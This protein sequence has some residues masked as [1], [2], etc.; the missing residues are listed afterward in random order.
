MGSSPS[1]AVLAVS[2]DVYHVYL[3]TGFD[4]PDKGT[5][6]K[7]DQGNIQII[8]N[9]G[10]NDDP[11]ATVKESEVLVFRDRKFD[12]DNEG[13]V[14]LEFF[15][16]KEKGV[17]EPK[18]V[19]I[20]IEGKGC[21]S[22]C[23]V[24]PLYIRE[25]TIV[26]NQVTHRFPIHNYL[27]PYTPCSACC[28]SSEKDEPQHGCAP[29]LY[30]Q[31]G[32]GSVH[33]DELEGFIKTARDKELN[34][35]KSM[36]PW[37]REDKVGPICGYVGYKKYNDLPRFLQFRQAWIDSFATSIVEGQR[38][39]IPAV[40]L[41][42][43]CGCC[44]EAPER[45]FKSF[46]HY[47]DCFVHMGEK[48]GWSKSEI[49][50]GLKVGQIFQQDPEF[51]RQIIQGPNSTKL[52]KVEE[53]SETWKA[54]ID[55]IPT[56]VID[57]EDIN[58][59][60]SD[61]RLYEIKN[62][63]TLEGIKHGGKLSK[64][65][66]GH[67]QTWYVTHADVLLFHSK[68]R[69]EE[70]AFVPILIR[71]E[72]KNDGEP[73]TFWYP[74]ENDVQKEDP[75]YLAWLFAK[76]HFRCADWGVYS[77]GTHYARAHAQNEVFAVSMYR[78]LSSSHPLFRLLKPHFQGIVGVNC[79]ARESLI[80]SD[81]NAFAKFMSSGDD[82]PQLLVNCCKELH[83]D[84][85]VVP[86][87]FET[88]GLKDVPN[89]FFR[90]DCEALWEI[91]LNYVQEMVDLS[92]HDDK[93]VTED[94]E[95]QHFV[96]EILEPGFKGFGGAG[97]PDSLTSKEKLVEYLTV[98]IFNVSCY[99]TGVNFQINKYLG[100]V[101]N[102]PPSLRTPPPKQDDVITMDH[103]MK[104]LPQ[105]ECAL[106]IMVITEVLGNFSPIERFY[107]ETKAEHKLGYLGENMAVSE[108]QEGCIKR[109]V[110]QMEGL[111]DTITKRNEGKYLAY[112]V[113]S[114]QNIPITT[115]T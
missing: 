19:K 39:I 27:S 55:K 99:H 43:L 57:G 9:P 56:H 34:I 44:G 86:K 25:V 28:G 70:E 11:K 10:A 79:Q 109:M 82:L 6:K 22:C 114:P 62:S 18:L 76:M 110:V 98:L 89:Y 51:G 38:K 16:D 49:K 106:A 24:D 33:H 68:A 94:H 60:I 23:C 96:K 91:L 37:E 104:S 107:V 72:N 93:T 1:R 48:V 66:T 103:I 20:E 15:V 75:T 83:Y 65:I 112:N 26:W 80:A 61:G 30:A 105:Y 59:V 32:G 41:N 14:D 21:S 115:Q 64:K 85:M 17:G 90:D 40:L 3:H 100:Y 101:P 45:D 50:D 7:W 63:G 58:T 69:P 84:N 53:L 29:Y 2:S 73:E 87:D 92:Y 54:G 67:N 113:L 108:E 46:A 71:L 42:C 8:I 102:A 88:R 111:R 95:L 31:P 35:I 77:I 97:F 78:N 5:V 36:V 81:Q 4:F 47:M 74:P 13:T 52:W 12:I